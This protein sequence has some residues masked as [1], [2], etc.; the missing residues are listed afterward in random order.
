MDILRVEKITRS[1]DGVR[2][3]DDVSFSIKEKTITG[4][5]GPNGAGKTTLFNVI[6]GFLKPDNGEVYYNGSKITGFPSYKTAQLGIGRLW[7]DIRIFPKL[8]ALENVLVS[9]LHQ[10]GE[11]PLISFFLP[12]RNQKAEEENIKEAK[13]WIEFVGLENKITLL[14]EDLSYGEQKL[15]ALA[16]LLA[17]DSKFLLLDEPATGIHPDIFHKIHSFIKDLVNQGK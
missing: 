7:Q 3:L 5:I 12:R 10:P 1:F 6:S 8:T 2:A 15:L 13:E 14:A 9:K 16:R 11:N 17:A 4:L